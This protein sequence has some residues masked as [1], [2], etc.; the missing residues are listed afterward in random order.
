MNFLDF[1]EPEWVQYILRR[2]HD[3][4]MWLEKTHKITKTTI[5]VVTYLISTS[6]VLGLR[7][8]KNQ[9]VLEEAGSQFHKREMTI[10]DIIEYDFRFVSMVIG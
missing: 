5:K 10:S 1:D 4:F 3:K 6:E 8:V 9:T 2:I 7:N